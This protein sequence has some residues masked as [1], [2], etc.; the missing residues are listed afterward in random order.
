MTEDNDPLF[1]ALRRL[2]PPEAP[3]LARVAHA[4]YIA[5]FDGTPP[6]LRWLRAGLVPTVLASVVVLYLFWAFTAATALV[7]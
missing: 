1:D 5:S 7:Q 6:A 4:A 2:P 3:K